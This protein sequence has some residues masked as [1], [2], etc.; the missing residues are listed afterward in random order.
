MLTVITPTIAGREELLAECVASVIEAGLSHDIELDIHGEG[1]AVLRNRMVA[2]ATTPWVLF[3]DDDDLLYPHYFD[4]VSEHFH[5]ADIVYTAW[6]LIGASEPQPIPFFNAD[7]LTQRNFIPVTACVRVSAF[8]AVGGFPESGIEEDHVL[9]KRLL[10][11]GYRFSQVPTIA[12][13]YRRRPN[14]RTPG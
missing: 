7:L 2:K 13:C 3:L 1:P 8:R 4:S 12:W 6:D 14:S 9:W 5:R 11:A 10:A